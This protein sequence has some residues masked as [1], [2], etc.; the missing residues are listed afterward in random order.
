MIRQ[1][2]RKSKNRVAHALRMAAE[3]LPHCDSYLAPRYRR[4]RSR[5]DGQEAVKPMAHYLA[6]L[7]HRLLTKGQEYVDR[8]AAYV[9]ARR[10]ERDMATLHRKAT[11]LGLK[12][13]PFA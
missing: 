6:R 7:V 10:T 5:M 2:A 9:G 1:K 8:G 12:L 4:L 13:V 3:S 11:E